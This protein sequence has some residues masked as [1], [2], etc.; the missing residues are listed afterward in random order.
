[1]SF[2]VVLVVCQLNNCDHMHKIRTIFVNEC[3]KK[4]NKCR[5]DYRWLRFTYCSSNSLLLWNVSKTLSLCSF[6]SQC[7]VW[8]FHWRGAV[9]WGAFTWQYYSLNLQNFWI[10]F[11]I[12]F[13]FW[14]GDQFYQLNW[15]NVDENH[16]QCFCLCHWMTKMCKN[17][18]MA[19]KKWQFTSFDRSKIMPWK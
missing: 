1:M 3:V 19:L 6:H 10:S 4:I 13:K 17:V 2:T 9:V 18:A 8:R 12:F 7:F 15:T 14:R 5:V 11:T 16:S